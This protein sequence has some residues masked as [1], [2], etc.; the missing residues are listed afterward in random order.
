M[1]PQYQQPGF[2]ISSGTLASFLQGIV[3][4]VFSTGFLGFLYV[5]LTLFVIA[6]ITLIMYLLVRLYEIRM[7]DKK[8]AAAVAVPSS[9]PSTSI[10]SGGADAG[11][12]AV[13]ET[14]RHIREKLLSDNGSDWKLGVIEADIYM[15]KVLDDHGFHGDTTSDKLKQVTADKLPS[16]S[17][18]W[19][20]HKVRNK[21]AHE[22]AAFVLTM[23]EARR[24]LTFY[25]MIYTDLGVI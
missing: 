16:V 23:P 9:L 18:A 17:I 14:W 20:V 22:G 10:P 5:L 15:D 1:Q 4:F 6:M 3:H 11:G 24:M 2:S 25:E 21:I 12:T 8:K 13:N 19:E 7:E